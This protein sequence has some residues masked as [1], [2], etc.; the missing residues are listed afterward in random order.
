MNLVFYKKLTITC[1][2]CGE[3]FE[4]SW[5]SGPKRER[6]DA[7]RRDGDKEARAKWYEA[8]KGEYAPR[9]APVANLKGFT[10]V[11]HKKVAKALE[12]LNNGD[13]GGKGRTD[14]LVDFMR[15]IS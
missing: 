2:M 9:T 14:K 1:K 7:C 13:A 3:T 5:N 12:R 8:N 11:D 6:C 15:R 10:D 4:Y